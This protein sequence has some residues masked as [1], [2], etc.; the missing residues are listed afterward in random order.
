M[1]YALCALSDYVGYFATDYVCYYDTDYVCYYA[2]D[3]V[4]YYATDYVCYNA[5]DCVWL[6]RQRLRALL[7]HRNVQ[8]QLRAIRKGVI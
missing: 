3:Y 1:Q 4:C 6:L 7:C 2:T 8:L 5:N